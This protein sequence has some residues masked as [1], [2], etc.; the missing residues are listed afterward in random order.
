MS[1]KEEKGGFGSGRFGMGTYGGPQETAREENKPEGGTVVSAG[2]LNGPNSITGAAPRTI[3]EVADFDSIEDFD[4]IGRDQPA[5]TTDGGMTSF[6]YQ[7][8]SEERRKAEERASESR[9]EWDKNAEDAWEKP[10]TQPVEEDKKYLTT[11]DREIITTE[12]GEAIELGGGSLEEELEAAKA[13]QAAFLAEN[14]SS[15][16]HAL[17]REGQIVEALEKRLGKTQ[18]HEDTPKLESDEKTGDVGTEA[19]LTKQPHTEL[20][21]DSSIE[22]NAEE[23]ETSSW[24][25]RADKEKLYVA[26]RSART[27]SKT[28]I[29]TVRDEI[30]RALLSNSALAEVEHVHLETSKKQLRDIRR[31]LDAALILHDMEEWSTDVVKMVFNTADAIDHIEKKTLYK[32]AKFL[33]DAAAVGAKLREWGHSLAEWIASGGGGLG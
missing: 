20:S 25:E 14:E 16:I 9:E 4:T 6:A 7:F 5:A 11:E 10:E 3:D 23:T 2:S 13:R 15:A 12:D 8:E 27:V 30:D 31:L 21:S 18:E 1:D 28:H 26:V 17:Y 22:T 33:T 19:T 32:D 24:K 29:E